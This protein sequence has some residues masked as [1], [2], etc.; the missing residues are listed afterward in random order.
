MS[1]L[2]PEPTCE[3]FVSEAYARVF[4]PT[5]LKRPRVC[6]HCPDKL[7]DGAEIRHARAPRTN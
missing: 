4:T 2:A 3:S 1:W 6:P 7:R 5:G